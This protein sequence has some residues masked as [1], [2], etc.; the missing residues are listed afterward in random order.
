MHSPLSTYASTHS[1][2]LTPTAANIYSIDGIVPEYVFDT[3]NTSLPMMSNNFNYTAV[4]EMSQ[5]FTVST[6]QQPQN[7]ILLKLPLPD[8]IILPQATVDVASTP[9]APIVQLVGL[10]NSLEPVEDGSSVLVMAG[11]IQGLPSPTTFVSSDQNFFMFV[12]PTPGAE[13][14]EG[15]AVIGDTYFRIEMVDGAVVFTAYPFEV[16]LCRLLEAGAVPEPG[17]GGLKNMTKEE[18]RAYRQGV[19]E[20]KKLGRAEKKED[21]KTKRAEK[22]EE[23]QEQKQAKD[24]WGKTKKRELAMPEEDHH[25][26]VHDHAH[27]HAHHHHDQEAMH[28][29][30]Q[31]AGRLLVFID[32]APTSGIYNPW[33]G[34]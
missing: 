28:R 10:I 8:G 32:F 26:H 25:A 17:L 30:L 9:E 21:A 3:S 5:T 22:R 2:P 14:V 4:V 31:T 18:R 6:A 20:L 19:K 27:D 15:G 13:W 11:M 33:N 7:S 12:D 1:A 34:S 23:A 29:Q 16:G 24:D